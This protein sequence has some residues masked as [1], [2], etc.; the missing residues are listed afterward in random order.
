MTTWMAFRHSFWQ[1]LIDLQSDI[2]DGNDIQNAASQLNETID[3]SAFKVLIEKFN[4]Q[5]SDVPPTLR[6]W[7]MFLKAIELV[8]LDL[9]ARRLGKWE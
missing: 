3:V 7:H 8:L 1:H 2:C 5:S 4:E 6:Y 9:Q